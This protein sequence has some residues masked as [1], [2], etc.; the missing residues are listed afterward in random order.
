MACREGLGSIFMHFGMTQARRT[1]VKR[2]GEKIMADHDDKKCA[3]ASCNCAAKEGSKYCGAYCEG[4][5][6]T[7]DITCGCGHPACADRL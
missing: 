3:H 1:G 5:A 7:A 6:D 2:A 4:S